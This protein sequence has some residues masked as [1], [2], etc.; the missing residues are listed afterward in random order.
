VRHITYVV[1]LAACS[2]GSP[3]S[4]A[5]VGEDPEDLPAPDPTGAVVL[6]DA[7]NYTFSGTLDAPS[8]PVAPETDVTLEWSTLTTNLRCQP[9]DPVADIDNT[10]LLYFPYLTE[11]EIEQGLSMDTLNQ[12]DLGVYLS[13]E[14]GDGTSVSLSQ[15]SF[16]GTDPEIEAQFT[17]ESG[18]WLVLLTSGTTIAVG[19]QMLAFL[20]PTAGETS[21]AASVTDGCP[22]LDYSADLA[23]ADRVPVLADGPWLLD[24]SAL[25]RDGQGSPFEPTRADALMVARFDE[26]ITDLEA[27]FLD[28]ELLAEETWTYTLGGGTT[29]DLGALSGPSD[30]FPGFDAAGTWALAL[31]CTTCPNPA[32]LFL[33][34]VVPS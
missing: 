23:S 29:A 22:V 14:P 31:R 11:A 25:T 28:L 9:L 21:T 26:S 7:A 30:P 33:T 6:T 10:A 12:A 8:F 13:Y 20:E 27:D 5:P 18:T 34:F 24:W 1:V 2:G 3:P 19:V 15:V 32:P 17:A 4:Q 16:F